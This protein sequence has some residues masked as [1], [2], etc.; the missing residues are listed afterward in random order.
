LVV[1]VL[2]TGSARQYDA[3][4]DAL[5]VRTMRFSKHGRFDSTHGPVAPSL[6]QSL[7]LMHGRYG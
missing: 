7:L 5:P 2:G 3:S 4:G 1:H 6:V